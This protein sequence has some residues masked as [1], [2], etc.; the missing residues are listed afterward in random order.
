MHD[1]GK[2]SVWKNEE[3]ASIGAGLAGD[4]E[5]YPYVSFTVNV[6]EVA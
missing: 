2:S 5:M 3:G 1:A 4:S 6:A